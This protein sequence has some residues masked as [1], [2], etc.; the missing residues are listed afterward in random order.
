MNLQ[1]CKLKKKSGKVYYVELKK[2]EQTKTQ[3]KADRQFIQGDLILGFKD[4]SN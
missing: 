1:K 4:R 2:L 3:R